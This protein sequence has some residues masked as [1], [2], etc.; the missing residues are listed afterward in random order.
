MGATFD[1]KPG[2]PQK[3]GQRRTWSVS[4]RGYESRG[5]ESGRGSS[6]PGTLSAMLRANHGLNQSPLSPTA[7]IRPFFWLM[8]VLCVAIVLPGRTAAAAARAAAGDFVGRNLADRRGH[9]GPDAV[10]L[11]PPDSRPGLADM[12]QPPFENVG[13]EKSQQYRQAFWYRR[14]FALDG[15]YPEVVRLKLHKAMYGTRVFLNGKLV[16]EH[17]PCFTP[18][19]FDIRRFLNPPGQ[20]NVLVV[21]VGAHRNELPR[22]FRTAGT[23]RGSIIRRAFTTRSS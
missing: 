1:Q 10:P 6:S 8:T 7:M 21:S 15:P 5:C 16:G 23:W 4:P 3:R 20:E 2:P 22:G 18:V 17:L 13:N 9:A 11:R 14:R 19:E 12:A